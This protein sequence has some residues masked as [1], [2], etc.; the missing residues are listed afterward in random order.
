MDK[1]SPTFTALPLRGPVG[2]SVSQGGDVLNFDFHPTQNSNEKKKIKLQPIIPILGSNQ[3]L[4][5]AGELLKFWAEYVHSSM[6]T[7]R[8]RWMKVLI[9]FKLSS[10]AFSSNCRNPAAARG[11]GVKVDPNSPKN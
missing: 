2:L 3:Q 8:Y 6:C 4:Y 7:S 11:A 9:F 5:P 10:T 1:R